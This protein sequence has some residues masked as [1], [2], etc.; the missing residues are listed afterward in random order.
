MFILFYFWYEF[1]TDYWAKFNY[2]NSGFLYS[3]NNNDNLI[4]FVLKKK[5]LLVSESSFFL[6]VNYDL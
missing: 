3:D 5:N 4:A 2:E 1:N 6:T